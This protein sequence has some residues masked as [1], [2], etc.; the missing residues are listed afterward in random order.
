MGDFDGWAES[1]YSV[2]KV[3][4]EKL[5]DRIKDLRCWIKHFYNVSTI[6]ELTRLK[7]LQRCMNFLIRAF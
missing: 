3:K 1:W 7:A 6:P 4:I 2:K 5:I